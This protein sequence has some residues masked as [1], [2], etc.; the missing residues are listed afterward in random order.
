M[1][2]WAQKPQ[3]NVFANTSDINQNF[4]YP[5]P[6]A[7]KTTN[8]KTQEKMPRGQGLRLHTIENKAFTGPY[9]DKGRFRFYTGEQT[10]EEKNR[11]RR[12]EEYR[13]TDS[14]HQAPPPSPPP[15][16]TLSAAREEKGE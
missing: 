14:R 11:L 13:E 10:K 16:P 9:K 3:A 5:R 7:V 8:I 6:S 4:P 12:A 1:E 2:S 15:P